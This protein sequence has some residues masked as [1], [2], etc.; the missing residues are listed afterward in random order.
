M[1]GNLI[2][3]KKDD[4]IDA[5]SEIRGSGFRETIETNSKSEIPTTDGRETQ[6]FEDGKDS[7]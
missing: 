2:S 1:I 3:R 4:S 5:S 7:A 6:M